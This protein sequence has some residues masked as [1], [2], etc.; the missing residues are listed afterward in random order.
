MTLIK[1]TEI[2]AIFLLITLG[3]ESYTDRFSS[4]DSNEDEKGIIEYRD[5][6]YY[7]I[8]GVKKKA[9]ELAYDKNDILR[10]EILYNE[11]KISRI[12]LYDDRGRVSTQEN[13]EVDLQSG[14]RIIF[15]TNGNIKEEYDF[16][17]GTKNGNYNSY[18][19]NG[20]L[21]SN[22]EFLNGKIKGSCSWYYP[23]GELMRIK[24]FLRKEYYQ[25]EYYKNGNKKSEGSMY[26]NN[27]ADENLISNS[28][29]GDTFIG[30]WI[31][32]NENGN[33]IKEENHK[34]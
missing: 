4:K 16:S 13:F 2:L 1:K 20:G 10:E 12:K 29:S 5:I 28:F 15:Y 14:K 21:K 23:S 22:L 3:C 6:K 33:I 17:N 7:Q 26:Y 25:I 31:F 19:I 24:E 11:N 34:Y 9:K 30:H 32:Y 27:I 18:Y 8:N